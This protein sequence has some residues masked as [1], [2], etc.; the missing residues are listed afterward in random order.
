LKTNS[1][2][3]HTLV[4]HELEKDSQAFNEF[5]SLISSFPQYFDKPDKQE[6]TLTDLLSRFKILLTLTRYQIKEIPD[7]GINVTSIEQSR[8]LDFDIA[9]VLGMDE[10]VTPSRNSG[11]EPSL[12]LV[13]RDSVRQKYEYEKLLFYN[14]LTNQRNYQHTEK[15]RFY[16]TYTK[17]TGSN[18]NMSHFLIKVK[19][20]FKDN[21]C[22]RHY[23]LDDTDNQK[24]ISHDSSETEAI[25]NII[26]SRVTSLSGHNKL[27]F[28]FDELN[29]KK[30][31]EAYQKSIY[32]GRYS[33]S[34]LEK[35]MNCKLS[36][37]FGQVLEY[38][39]KYYENDDTVFSSGKDKGDIY[40]AIFEVICIEL[41]ESKSEGNIDLQKLKS[42]YQTIK[43]KNEEE[44]LDIIDDTIDTI[45]ESISSTVEFPE[46]EANSKKPIIKK[47][48]LNLINEQSG[49]I[50]AYV[51]YSINTKIDYEPE[52]EL[53]QNSDTEF[54]PYSINFKATIDRVDVIPDDINNMVMRVV[55]YKTGSKPVTPL[56]I[57]KNSIDAQKNI[58][59]GLYAYLADNHIK[60]ETQANYTEDRF[61]TE[62]ILVEKVSFNLK[63]NAVLFESHGLDKRTKAQKSITK[64]DH[65][66]KI[67]DDSL[68]KV[69]LVI[70]SLKKFDFK[71]EEYKS[72][73]Y[74]PHPELCKK[75]ASKQFL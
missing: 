46:Y 66:L 6:H 48:I 61:E 40:H 28:T 38:G 1:R 67:E 57:L 19:D 36:Y 60:F 56:N 3:E 41:F 68:T 18:S 26:N 37:L 69:G 20:L 24:I 49:F 4:R 65:V 2:H 43:D 23:P 44:I 52:N 31:Y 45:I 7:Y 54:E 30:A 63:E 11:T 42:Q 25:K 15:D 74:C 10:G 13:F 17:G 21:D 51:E 22:F 9:F 75:R 29:H 47:Y 12:E 39:S 55:D 64:R 53:H 62:D 35:Y 33:A 71:K 58:Q 34:K 16:F 32:N 27:D 72:C 50:P 59:L 70:G 5:I 14:L 8:E 73:S